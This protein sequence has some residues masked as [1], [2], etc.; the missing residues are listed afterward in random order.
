MPSTP[1]TA[2]SRYPYTPEV[3]NA[4]DDLSF[5]QGQSITVTEVVDEDWLY[6][7]YKD[8]TGEIQSG[9]FPKNFVAVKPPTQLEEKATPPAA[10]KTVEASEPS[11]IISVPEPKPEAVPTQAE[12]ESAVAKKPAAV[13]S[14]LDVES[15]PNV[16][17]SVASFK[18]RVNTFNAT[19]DAP[20]PVPGNVPEQSYAKKQFVVAEHSS[21]VPPPIKTEPPPVKKNDAP[22]TADVV[23]ESTQSPVDEGPKMTLKERMRILEDQQLKEEEAVTA[24]LKRKEERKQHRLRRTSTGGTIKSLETTRTGESVRTTGSRTTTT[25]TVIDADTTRETI[26][27]VDSD[28][29]RNIEKVSYPAKDGD[30]LAK[31]EDEVEQEEVLEGEPEKDA[32]DLIEETE[33]DAEE[34]KR[35]ELRE[36]MAKL[37]GGMGMFGMFG[38]GG[39]APKSAPASKKHEEPKQYVPREQEEL[40]KMP[41]IVPIMPFSKLPPELEKRVE[42]ATPDLEQSESDEYEEAEDAEPETPEEEEK[43]LETL[44]TAPVAPTASVA[45]DE[46]E[47]EEEESSSDVEEP[48]SRPAPPPVPTTPAKTIPTTPVKTAPPPIPQSS[49]VERSLPPPIPQSSPAKSERSLPP[50]IPQTSP[51]AE[52]P[53]PPPVPSE[54]PTVPKTAAPTQSAPPPPPVTTTA[55]PPV[56]SQAPGAAP[57]QLPPAPQAPQVPQ[58]PAPPA[59]AVASQSTGAS[60]TQN[61]D[62]SQT[63]TTPSVNILNATGTESWWLQKRLPSTISPSDVYFE[64]EEH[65]VVKR[66]G[67]TIVYLDYYIVS[68]DL[69]SKMWEVSYDKSQPDKLISHLETAYPAP[70]SP[71]PEYLVNASQRY[72]ATAYRASAANLNNELEGSLVEHIYNLLPED[73]LPPIAGKTFGAVIYKNNHNQNIQQIDDIRPGDVLVVVKGRLE[74]KNALRKVKVH[75]L[76]FDKPYVAFVTAYDQQKQKIKL[77]EEYDDIARV[78]SIKL[79]E[80]KSGKVRVFRLVGRDYI[81]W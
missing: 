48:V 43:E 8:D 79:G 64:T 54:A 31:A 45:A 38:S 40:E 72:G 3:E 41:A 14:G 56:P 57:P 5:G 28:D 1:Y 63:V 15:N 39:S 20:P 34:L 22:I 32:D 53:P 18:T 12:P 10:S 70:K 36:R 71:S 16:T 19:D 7:S 80:L 21:Y 37:S 50:P 62:I 52:R 29:E 11:K 9:Y 44:P 73:T 66:Y 78:S 55:P 24:A 60:R 30:E 61:V 13:T 68:P 65:E 6:G 2:I 74:G 58:V 69:S 76:G 46:E 23:S 81:G 26:P 47:D 17:R 49:P 27:E 35:K 77:V 67:R 42:A 51:V 59:R 4:G 75:E 25:E 33:E